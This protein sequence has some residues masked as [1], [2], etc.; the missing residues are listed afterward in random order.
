MNEVES[1]SAQKETSDLVLA[2]LEGEVL[3]PVLFE[4]ECLMVLDL[5]SVNV[6]TPCQ[7]EAVVMLWKVLVL[8]NFEAALMLVKL[9]RT[10]AV[11]AAE[12]QQLLWLELV[13]QLLEY[14]SLPSLHLTVEMGLKQRETKP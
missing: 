4:V 12:L 14:E 7:E 13:L 3:R 9:N 1:S 6:E 11:C 8:V 10:G 5:A 2:A